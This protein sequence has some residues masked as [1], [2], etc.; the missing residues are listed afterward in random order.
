MWAGTPWSRLLLNMV[1]TWL[2]I[3]NHKHL[4]L[5]P[6]ASLVEWG[7]DAHTVRVCVCVCIKWILADVINVCLSS[8]QTFPPYHLSQSDLLVN[9]LS[10]QTPESLASRKKKF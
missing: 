5:T 8:R 10:E 2:G 9:L 1:W 6:S 7:E 4:S 3:V